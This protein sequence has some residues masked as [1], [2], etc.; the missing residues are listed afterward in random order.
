MMKMMM[1]MLKMIMMI[2]MMMMV[3]MMKKMM[4][5]MI[6]M[7]MMM[8]M[9]MIMMIM[10]MM[11]MM[12]MIIII[13]M[14]MMIMII[15]TMNLINFKTPF[16]TKLVSKTSVEILPVVLRRSSSS[17]KSLGKKFRREGRGF[18]PP[19]QAVLLLADSPVKHNEEYAN[20]FSPSGNLAHS[21]SLL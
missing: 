17:H 1:L 21:G 4:M 2:M 14:M 19:A 12:K 15:I 8:M 18:G 11:M 3:M 9:K 13:M 5:K 20:L 7:I 16:E 6:M 10:M